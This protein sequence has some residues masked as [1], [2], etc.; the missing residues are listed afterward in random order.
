MT[1]RI[2]HK[3][4]IAH[5]ILSLPLLSKN[6]VMKNLLTLLVIAALAYL[7]PSC[8]EVKVKAI[9]L[10]AAD[11]NKT[12]T[13]TVDTEIVLRLAANSSTGYSWNFKKLDDGLKLLNDNYETDP[14]YK[15][16]DGAGGTH[17]FRFKT[18]KPGP[19]EIWLLYYRNSE[20]EWAQQYKVTVNVKR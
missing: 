4:G 19:S 2:S 1:C 14:R 9:Q 8:A 12:I 6:T 7:L 17:T 16:R 11:N 3:N 18:V 20:D 15:D 5:S 13:A 10:T